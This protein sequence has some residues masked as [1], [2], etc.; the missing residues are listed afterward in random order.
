MK[1]PN[2]IRQYYTF[3]D[4]INL[5]FVL[6]YATRG[7]L[8]KLI[9]EV[10]LTESFP[11]EMV[12]FYTAELLS[13]L[14]YIHNKGAVHRDLQPDNILISEDWHIKIVRIYIFEMLDRFW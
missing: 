9:S 12:R 10:A 13:G 4:D 3:Q 8:T 5:Y 7:S 1:H 14:E 6:E 11:M 2:I